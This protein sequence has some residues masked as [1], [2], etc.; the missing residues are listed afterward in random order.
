[1]KEGEIMG[2]YQQY[3]SERLSS[4]KSNM[5]DS[6]S[7]PILFVGTGLSRRYIGAPDWRGLLNLLIL[8]NPNIRFP[9]GYYQQDSKDLAEVASKIINDYFDF[10][11]SDEVRSIY[12][13]ELYEYPDKSIFLKYTVAQLIEKY[14]SEFNIE[15]HEYQEELEL[16]AKLT[17][18]AIVTTNY[19]T[20]LEELFKGKYRTVVGQQIIKG[21]ET[22]RIGQIFKIHGCVT[23][24]EEIVISS[25]DYENFQMKQ[26]YLSAKLLTYFIEH[27]VIFL[28]YSISDENIKGILGN[29]SEMLCVEDD[30]IENIWLVEW[31][32]DKIG[33]NEKPPTEKV[34]N[35]GDNKSIRINYIYIDEFQ[36]IFKTL[37]QGTSADIEE[38]FNLQDTVY[39]IVKSKTVTDLEVDVISFKENWTE[40]RLLDSLGLKDIVNKANKDNVEGRE[41]IVSLGVIKDPEQILAHYPYRLIDL[42]NKLG[43]KHWHRTN[44]LI[45][46]IQ[47]KT[48]IDIK[49]T[50]NEYHIDVG[51]GNTQHRYS[52]KMLEVLLGYL[53]SQEV[54]IVRLNGEE[55]KITM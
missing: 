42:A 6:G 8:Q 16:L 54:S 38:L 24:P 10:A 14:M 18:H 9:L 26:K 48:G 11:W 34:I 5:Y 44:R 39:N 41:V 23:Q 35:L 2:N 4:L 50:N 51:V 22:N 3:L 40:D 7:R 47:E 30:L 31:S 27:P 1:M 13:D 15:G 33:E 19:D 55:V 52:N 53:N 36:E 21:T 12:P 28:G 20:M 45:D 37:S 43:D 17:P 46:Q 32:K 29:I 25:N 49:G